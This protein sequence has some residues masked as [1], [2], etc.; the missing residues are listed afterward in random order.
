MYQE[1][2]IVTDN[3]E[4]CEL[5]INLDNPESEEGVTMYLKKAATNDED[6]EIFAYINL[7]KSDAKIVAAFLN[8]IS[9]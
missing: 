8:S 6:D 3:K 2:K 5:V 7:L 9:V 1:L 4:D